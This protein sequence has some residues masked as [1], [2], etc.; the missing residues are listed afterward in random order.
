VDQ[1]EFDIW[2]DLIETICHRIAPAMTAFDPSREVA[3]ENDVLNS[4]GS[5][6]GFGVG[7]QRFTVE[8][9]TVFRPAESGAEPGRNENGPHVA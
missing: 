4:T 2:R 1:D 9:G 7:P 3:D 5:Q 6:C 8:Y